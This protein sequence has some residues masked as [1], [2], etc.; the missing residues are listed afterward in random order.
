MSTKGR[1]YM[2]CP[3]CGRQGVYSKPGDMA[4][5]DGYLCRYSDCQWFVYLDGT[6]AEDVEKRARLR[7]L[8]PWA[9]GNL[10]VD[11]PY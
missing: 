11:E 9:A 5:E 2:E 7:E 6:Y 3:Q 10:I 1:R 8:N 4:G